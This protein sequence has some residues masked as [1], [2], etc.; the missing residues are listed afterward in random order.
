M[1][2]VIQSPTAE[3]LPIL[4]IVIVAVCPVE[5]T[6]TQPEV[7]KPVQFT[8]PYLYSTPLFELPAT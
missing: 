8:F 6:L 5:A 7:I 2:I 1:S 3:A 4:V